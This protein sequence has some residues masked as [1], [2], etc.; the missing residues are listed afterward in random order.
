[1]PWGWETMFDLSW[2]ARD[3][4]KAFTMVSTDESSIQCQGSASNVVT[5]TLAGCCS[6]VSI[7]GTAH[8]WSTSRWDT[9]LVP[10]SE[11][12]AATFLQMMPISRK[13]R[14]LLSEIDRNCWRRAMVV[15]DRWIVLESGV[16]VSSWERD[17]RE[18]EQC[19]QHVSFR[20]QAVRRIQHLLLLLRCARYTKL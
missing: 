7:A 6:N 20:E 14:L 11:C 19:V 12:V 13:A 4:S 8:I 18:L 15:C 9:A 5:S 16:F 3:F 17:N 1:M 2:I 10:R